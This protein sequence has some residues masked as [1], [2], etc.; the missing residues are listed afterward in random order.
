MFCQEAGPARWGPGGP[1]GHTVEAGLDGRGFGEAGRGR[2][3]AHR[4]LRARRRL[5]G[6]LEPVPLGARS[7]GPRAHPHPALP[8]APPIP[9]LTHAQLSQ[10]LPE[11]RL[12]LQHFEQVGGLHPLQLHL[13]VHV[14][15]LVERDVHEAGAVAAVF[16]GIQAWQ[17]RDGETRLGG[18]GPTV[19]VSAV[20][21]RPQAPSRTLKA[22]FCFYCRELSKASKTVR[23]LVLSRH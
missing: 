15:L 19:F 1:Q 22:P 10:Q 16:A 11:L 6:L 3:A 21:R 20:S 7:H 9:G 18:S 2:Q 12:G 23:Y 13:P 14:D 17:V 8:A 4:D 5:V